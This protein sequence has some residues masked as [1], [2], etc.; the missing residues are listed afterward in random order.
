MLSF[1][2][3]LKVKTIIETN[4][5][6]LLGRN[7]E[8]QAMYDDFRNSI[9]KTWLDVT[10]YLYV[11]KFNFDSSIND[12]NKMIAIRPERLDLDKKY[13]YPNDF[14]YNFSSKIKHYVL[15]KLSTMTIEEVNEK[16]IMLMKEL[17]ADDYVTYINPVALKSIEDIGITIFII[18][19]TNIIIIIIEHGHILIYK[20]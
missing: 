17:N 13:T 1:F 2:H 14:P 11:T 7:D 3:T 20:K 5:L 12:D 9:S 4:R 15:W 10:N 16:A 6:E 8:Q 19:I 18:I